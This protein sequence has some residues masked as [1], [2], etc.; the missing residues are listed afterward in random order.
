M[1]KPKYFRVSAEYYIKADNIEHAERIVKN[2]MDGEYFEQHILIQEVN[3]DDYE[4]ILSGMIDIFNPE[5][6]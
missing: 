5:N 6:I 1:E 2:E 4:N 3:N